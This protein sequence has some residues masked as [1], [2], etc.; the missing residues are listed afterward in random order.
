[1]ACPSTSLT[2]CWS[3]QNALFSSS[4][5]YLFLYLLFLRCCCFTGSRPLNLLFDQWF[6]TD[7]VRS[8]LCAQVHIV[9]VLEFISCNHAALSALLFFFFLNSSCS[10]LPMYSFDLYLSFIKCFPVIFYALQGSGQVLC[11]YTG[12]KT[13]PPSARVPVMGEIAGVN[14]A[15]LGGYLHSKKTRTRWAE[16]FHDEPRVR[17]G[18]GWA[19]SGCTLPKT[20]HAMT[21][22]P[23]HTGSVVAR[24]NKDRASR[25]APGRRCQVC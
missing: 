8:F 6:K 13:L 11:T 25:R 12:R 16:G 19:P 18:E 15:S 7:C 2:Y 3:F 1:M 20:H 9:G 23:Y 5:A 14:T 21:T 4:F 17:P 22:Q 10:I 24:V